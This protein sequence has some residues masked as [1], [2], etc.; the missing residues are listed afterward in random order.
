[1]IWNTIHAW[2][3]SSYTFIISLFWNEQFLRLHKPASDFTSN[4]KDGPDDS[5]TEN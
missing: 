5:Q 2:N 3:W 4:F 1:M